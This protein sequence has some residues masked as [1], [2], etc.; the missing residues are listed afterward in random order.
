MVMSASNG[1]A[2]DWRLRVLVVEDNPDAAESMS[3]LLTMAGH[4]VEVAL[5][6][7]VAVAAMLANHPD[8][9]L[10]DIGLPGM[11]GWQVARQLQ[12]QEMAKRPLLVAVSG[13]DS[14]EAMRRSRDAGID[15]HLVKPVDPDHLQQLLHRFERIIGA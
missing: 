13:R 11:D 5:N 9:V 14:E 3:L 8:V 2:K 15:L 10:L 4:D 6:G 1:K 7:E 12:G